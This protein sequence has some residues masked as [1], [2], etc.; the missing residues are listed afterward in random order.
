MKSKNKV[1]AV[2]FLMV[3]YKLTLGILQ[4]D[5]KSKKEKKVLGVFM[6]V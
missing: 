6:V 2:V 1:L 4:L 3:V 5:M